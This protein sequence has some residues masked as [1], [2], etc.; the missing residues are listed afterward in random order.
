[1]RSTRSDARR[2]PGG[3]TR[4]AAA[5]AVAAG[6]S[7]W[8]FSLVAAPYLASHHVVLAHG[9]VSL[10]AAVAAVPYAVGQFV[11]H[12]R[13]DRSFRLWNTQMPVCARCLGLYAA[14]PLGL[15]WPMR[16]GRRRRLSQ[17]GLRAVVL[18]AAAPTGAIV[19][20]EW[21]GVA[22]AGL[23]VRAIAA[24]PLGAVAA[25][26]LATACVWGDR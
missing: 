15:I 13:A 24:L 8:L 25:S 10:S 2:V 11:C 21:L 5:W 6:A 18:L 19:A 4:R 22:D 16:L 23:W 17:G 26:L 7:L 12:Q 3:G 14:A 20:A 9:P 1:M